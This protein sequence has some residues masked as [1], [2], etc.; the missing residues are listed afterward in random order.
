MSNGC[1]RRSDGFSRID[2]HATCARLPK[3]ECA[4]AALSYAI[5]LA[6][7]GEA[8]PPLPAWACLARSCVAPALPVA[9]DVLEHRGFAN[10]V[11]RRRGVGPLKPPTSPSRRSAQREL[12]EPSAPFLGRFAPTADAF[13]CPGAHK[14]SLTNQ[15]VARFGFGVVSLRGLV[16][17]FGHRFVTHMWGRRS[18]FTT[19][20]F[21]RDHML[22]RAQRPS[23]IT[24]YWC[25]HRPRILD[26]DCTRLDAAGLTKSRGSRRT[27]RLWIDATGLS[28]ACAGR[29]RRQL[30]LP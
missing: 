1:C 12:R 24:H 7:S 28:R 3:Y 25:G 16:G 22:S 11:G 15:T 30:D 4:H 13:A 5:A 20:A 21:D 6:P 14:C 23:Q 27:I 29:W 9:R 10:L 19:S 18:V 26:E 2:D 17:V 8:D